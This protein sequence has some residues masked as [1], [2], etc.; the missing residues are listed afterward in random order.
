MM[1]TKRCRNVIII[2]KYQGC[3]ILDTDNNS[4]KDE[5][6]KCPVISGTVTK[7]GNPIT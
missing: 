3:P 4:V 6:D 2:A 5:A 7:I 1:Q